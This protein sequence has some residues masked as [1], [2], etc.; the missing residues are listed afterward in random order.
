MNHVGIIQLQKNQFRQAIHSFGSSLR[1]LN[2]LLATPRFVERATRDE[3]NHNEDDDED[4]KEG[5]DYDDDED[6]VMLDDA[7]EDDHQVPRQVSSGD[8]ANYT[9]DEYCNDDESPPQHRSY[10]SDELS[11]HHSQLYKTPIRISSHL[12]LS[13]ICPTYDVLVT[14]SISIMFNFALSHHLAAATTVELVTVE[15]ALDTSKLLD[16]SVALYEL[17]HTLQQQVGIEL[18]IEHTMATICNL[19]HI[20]HTRGDTDKA[21]KCFQHLLAIIVF[22]QCQYRHIQDDLPVRREDD[23]TTMGVLLNADNIFF[24]SVSHLI[25]RD[26]DMAAAA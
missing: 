25:L 3:L 1:L 6:E 18:S 26:S 21:T 4:R 24:Q 14:M 19:G 13:D 20:H 22:L 2:T 17:T 7:L 8:D 12:L 16:Q 9:Q 10:S 11:R 5:E 15:Q 23:A